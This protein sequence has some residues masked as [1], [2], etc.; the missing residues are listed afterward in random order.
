[1]LPIT[2][3]NRIGV[4]AQDPWEALF[5]FTRIVSQAGAG[6]FI[7]HARKAL[8]QGLSPKEN[9]EVPPLD[10]DIVR[11]LKRQYP[12]L[13]IV[14]NGGLADLEQAKQECRGLDGVML[15]RAA[16]HD[17]ALLVHVDKMFLGESDTIVTPQEAYVAFRPY[18]AAQLSKGVPLH[19]MTRHMLGLFAG[20]PGARLFR[21]FLS[22]NSGPAADIRT[23]DSALEIVLA[24]QQQVSR[25]RDLQAHL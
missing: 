11:A 20:Q 13:T 21:R 3:K 25:T 7:V 8:L 22:E 9:R 2:V 10:Y 15:G 16:Y 5:E 4:D 24:A 12:H 6:I 17:P 14:L 18:V 23:Y 1:A 19:A